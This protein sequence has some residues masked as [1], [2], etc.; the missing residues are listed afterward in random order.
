MINSWLE[1]SP[2]SFPEDADG[3]A[4]A[5]AILDAQLDIVTRQRQVR[6]QFAMQSEAIKTEL[7]HDFDVRL[8]FES[9]AIEGISASFAE[10]ETFLRGASKDPKFVSAYSFGEQVKADPKLLEVVGHGGALRFVRD[11]ASSLDDRP[12]R[13]A[14][15]RSIH[16]LAMA[17]EP[18]IAGQYK[19]MDNS[20]GGR[21]DLLT[22][23]SDDIGYHMRHL[24]DW[25][26]ETTIHGPLPAVVVHAWLAILHP[27]DDGNGRVARLLSNYVLFRTGW[28]CLILRSG[29][30]RQRYYDALQHSD[31]GGDIAPLYGLF[32]DGLNRT[33]T[34]MEDPDFAR[35]LLAVDLERRDLFDTWSGMAHR[36]LV[37]TRDEM[38]RFGFTLEVVGS[39]AESDFAWLRRRDPAGNGWWAKV[40]G[41]D[42]AEDFLLWFGYQSEDLV[43]KKEA[44]TPTPSIFVSERNHDPSWLHPFRPLWDDPEASVVELSLQP[45][46]TKERVVTR[47]GDGQVNI[48]SISGAAT[49]LAASVRSLAQR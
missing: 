33:L 27:F 7:E 15:I 8:V 39:L 42:G 25:L 26:Q 34:E 45:R 49:D 17:S 31:A 11:L 38:E 20:I 35:S 36:L 10:T 43:D 24:V 21:E 1:G 13:E 46:S 9:N 14:D 4:R 5:K 23:R 47:A 16:A 18:R 40:R 2:Y 22:A 28:P 12:L 44:A 41:P 30:D 3:E 6:E 37:E 19:S 48:R 32:I 29:P